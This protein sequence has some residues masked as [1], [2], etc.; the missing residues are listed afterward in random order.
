MPRQQQQARAIPLDRARETL[1][2]VFSFEDFRDGQEAV[3][4][5]LLD[6]KS[7]LSI[8]PTGAGKSLCYQL[9]ALL[10]DGLTLVISPLIALMK[11]QIDFLVSH[12]VPAARLD[13]SLEREEA[14][15]AYDDLNSGRLKLLYISPERLANERF[16]H[17]L[18]RRKISLL[19]VD[20][21]HCISEWG[22]NFRPDYL[23]IARLA[24]QLDVGCVLAL[25]ATATPEVARDTAKAFDISADD[26]VHTGFYRPN[27]KLCVTPCEGAERKSLLLS[28][29]RERPSD[30]PRS[31]VALNIRAHIGIKCRDRGG[32]FDGNALTIHPGQQLVMHDVP[33][34]DVHKAQQVVVHGANTDVLDVGLPLLVQPTRRLASATSFDLR[35]G[36][37]AADQVGLTQHAIDARR[38]HRDNAFIQHFPG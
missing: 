20:E 8:F 31:V 17:S 6:G 16:L 28:R 4:T 2:R 37:P 23:K 38:R 11:D 29:L 19:A 21:A 32:R 25:T 27:L 36:L 35:L 15:Q 9:P 30:E 24:R 10:L 1:K 3:I 22:H 12:D 18:Q 34:V 26:V 7:V 14:L 5:R 13:S 33:R